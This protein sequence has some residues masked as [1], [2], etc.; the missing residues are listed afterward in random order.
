MQNVKIAESTAIIT[1]KIHQQDSKSGEMSFYV[2]G[3]FSPTKLG[4]MCRSGEKSLKLLMHVKA[5]AKKN[6]H[7][8]EGQT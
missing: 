2:I 7:P 4:Q 1:I 8:F 6:L 3:N 5:K